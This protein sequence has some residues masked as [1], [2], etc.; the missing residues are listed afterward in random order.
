MLQ[1]AIG[2]FPQVDG[3]Y[4]QDPERHP[5]AKLHKRL[6]FRDVT[7][8]NLQVMD[9]TAITLC[10]ENNIP[11]VVFNLRTPGNIM[12]ALTGDVSIGTLVAAQEELPSEPS[13]TA[14]LAS[15]R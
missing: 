12:R 7:L 3:V 5:G 1:Q 11:V 8:Q 14:T 4:D 13:D 10:K 9:E 2:W 6:S 15:R